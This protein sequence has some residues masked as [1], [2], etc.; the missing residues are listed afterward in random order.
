MLP[1]L[2]VVLIRSTVQSGWYKESG[3]D[4]PDLLVLLML[5]SNSESNW[6]LD[7][8][9]EMITVQRREGCAFFIVTKY[10]LIFFTSFLQAVIRRI[11]GYISLLGFFLHLYHHY[12]FFVSFL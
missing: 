6:Q 8:M 4:D 11:R 10:I 5:R 9:D 12:Y 2:C 1:I 3:V 7:S